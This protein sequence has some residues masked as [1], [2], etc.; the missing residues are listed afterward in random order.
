MNSQTDEESYLES[1]SLSTINK[2]AAG[3]DV[4]S[5]EHW[6][7]VPPDR[8]EKNVRCFGCFTPDL[9]AMADWLLECQVDTVAMEATGVYCLTLF[10]ILEAKDLNVN[11]VNAH[12]VKTVPGRKSDVLDCQ[13]LQKLHTFGLLSASF[14]PDDQICVLRSY[15]RQRETLIKESGTHVQ[16]M[17]KALIQMN[18]QLQKRSQ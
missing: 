6:V 4:G 3:I 16:R 7:C 14:R 9:I 2:N 8:A 1:N 5:G 11:L 17:Q 15:L 13:W 18:L 10:Q 12:H